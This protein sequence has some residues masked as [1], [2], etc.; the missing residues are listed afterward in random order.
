MLPKGSLGRK[1]GLKL[2]VYAD[3]NHKHEAQNPEVLDITN[4]I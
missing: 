4:L 1:Q 3:A 2:H